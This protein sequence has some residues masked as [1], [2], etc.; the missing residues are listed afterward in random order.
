[1]TIT[2]KHGSI[3][4]GKCLA[5]EKQTQAALSGLARAAQRAVSQFKEINNSLLIAGRPRPSDTEQ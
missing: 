1:M 5:C 4:Y 2:C 3:L